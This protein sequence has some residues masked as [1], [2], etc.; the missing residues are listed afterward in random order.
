M[1]LVRLLSPH[2]HERAANKQ[3]DGPFRNLRTEVAIVLLVQLVNE[4]RGSRPF[5]LASLKTH[6]GLLPELGRSETI[7]VPNV[8]QP[9]VRA[10]FVGRQ[11]LPQGDEPHVYRAM[12]GLQ[13]TLLE[14]LVLDRKSRSGATR[15]LQYLNEV[16]RQNFQ[17]RRVVGSRFIRRDQCR[18]RA[19]DR[20][21][22]HD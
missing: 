2:G 11:T 6:D 12:K 13:K 10:L 18:S 14:S 5:I 1:E 3:A 9:V 22:A 16:P 4:A 8:G 19:D 17:N 7:L 21:A 15:C 20:I